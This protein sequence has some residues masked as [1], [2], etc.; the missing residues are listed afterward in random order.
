VTWAVDERPDAGPAT[1]ACPFCGSETGIERVAEDELGAQSLDEVETLVRNEWRRR[2]GPESYRRAHSRPF[3][4][5]LIVFALS[6]ESP[7][8]GVVVDQLLWGEVALL[9]TWGLNRSA[10]QAE[11]HDLAEAIRDVLS[12]TDL[13]F[14]R[15]RGLADLVDQK[16]RNTLDWPVPP[17]AGGRDAGA[18]AT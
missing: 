17:P 13:A 8:R 18:R 16:V 10:I 11:L 6:P 5:A 1:T 9:E 14:D 2:L 15:T 7:V 4:R 12:T 3:I